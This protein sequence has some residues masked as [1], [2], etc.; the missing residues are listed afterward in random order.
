MKVIVIGSGLSA[1][2]AIIALRNRGIKPVVI[3]IA[4]NHKESASSVKN[5]LKE[6]VIYNKAD[7]KLQTSR[8]KGGFSDIWSASI[9]CPPACDLK[10]WDIETLPLAEDYKECTAGIF[11]TAANDDLNDSFKHPNPPNKK[12]PE[13]DAAEYLISKL[14]PA[15][16]RAHYSAS[17]GRARQLINYEKNEIFS[18]KQKIESMQRKN[19]ITYIAD[20]NVKN[21]FEKNNMVYVDFICNGKEQTLEGS[22][23]FIATGAVNTTKILAKFCDLCDTDLHLRYADSFIL[24]F[25]VSKHFKYEEKIIL[26]SIFLELMDSEQSGTYSHIQISKPNEVILELL[27]YNQLPHFIKKSIKYGLGYVYTA[28][29]TNHSNISG[30]YQISV[31]SSDAHND[32][33][34][35]NNKKLL[36]QKRILK[37]VSK[38]LN[39][40]GGYNLPMLSK[41]F[42]THF[43]IGGSFPMTKTPIN[44]NDTDILGRPKGAKKVYAVDASIF[45]SIPATTVGLIAMANAHRIARSAE[46]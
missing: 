18:S 5:A 39:L 2:G 24:P 38:L 25:F 19:E 20:S 44:A 23:A 4:S 42:E 9:L 1:L 17:I 26:S 37:K 8:Q 6:T 12:P 33:L 27:K 35:Q 40:A 7:P 45:P 3:D 34:I 11:Y 21:I 16:Y 43:Y 14:K 13:D 36:E 29:C 10:G 15:I 31:G 41:N 32:L 22:S 28:L 46:L 30:S